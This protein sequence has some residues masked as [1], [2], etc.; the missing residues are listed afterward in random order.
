MSFEINEAQAACQASFREFV[1][2]EIEPHANRWDRDERIPR[3][4]FGLLAQKGF[5]GALVPTDHGGSGLDMVTFGLLNEE[6]GRGCSSVRSLLTVHSMVEY[7]ILRWGNDAQ[8]KQWLPK[9]ARGEAIGAFGLTEPNVGSD[10]KSVETSA[11]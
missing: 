9:L 4:L 8:K 6:V 10:A 3:E 7:A 2:S 1:L 5:L 11:E